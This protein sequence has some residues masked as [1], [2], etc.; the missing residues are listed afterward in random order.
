MMI[1]RPEALRDLCGDVCHISFKIFKSFP[2]RGHSVF[3]QRGKGRI[4]FAEHDIQSFVHA[5]MLPD[6][7]PKNSV[8]K[9]T[10]VDMS[11]RLL[12]PTF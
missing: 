12:D 4:R 8:A 1:E 7:A 6:H 3:E 2:E 11:A 5:D 10:E 9:R